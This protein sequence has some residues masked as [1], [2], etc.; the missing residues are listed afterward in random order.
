VLQQK[1]A[2]AIGKLGDAVVRVCNA[3][4]LT[5]IITEMLQ[6]NPDLFSDNL[7]LDQQNS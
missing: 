5:E 2:M 7:P 3:E 1:G 6:D 4:A